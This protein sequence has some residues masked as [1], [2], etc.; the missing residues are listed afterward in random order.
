MS[1]S[2]RHWMRRALAL[3][4]R[5]RGYVEP[6]PLVGAVVVRDG[7]IVG[8]GWHQRFGEAHAEVNAIAEAG[9]AARGA[10]LFVTLE[11]CCHRGKTPPCTEALLRAG[12]ARVVLAMLDPFPLVSGQGAAQL[13]AAGVTVEEGMVEAEAR[14]LNAPYLTLLHNGRPFVLAKWAMTLDGKIATRTGDSQWISNNESRRRVHELRGRMDAILI[15]IGTALAD[16]PQLTARPPGPRTA[17]RIVLDR[18]CR[19]PLTSHLAKTASIV[20]T[21]IVT[22]PTAPAEAVAALEAMGCEVLRLPDV[23]S[24]LAELGR[25][26]MTNLLVEGASGVL[27]SFLDA[28]LIDEVHVFIAPRLAGGAA[29]RTPIGGLGVET[30]SQ[31]LNVNDWEVESIAGDLYIRGRPK[32]ACDLL[33]YHS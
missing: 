2:S 19:L 26:R 33:I 7:Q 1:T 10:T 17:T 13:R 5:G 16:D 25:R 31:A 9:E 18:H 28:Q 4:E 29:A 24:L 21:L 8:E 22:T 11:P 27:G 20:P 14:R 15:G 12:V 23:A 3:A 30:I 6:N 32:T